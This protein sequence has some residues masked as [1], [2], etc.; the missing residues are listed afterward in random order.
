[1]TGVSAA[2]EVQGR[3]SYSSRMKGL[4]PELYQHSLISEHSRQMVPTTTGLDC[5]EGLSKQSTG[6]LLFLEP[7]PEQKVYTW[8]GE[9]GQAEPAGKE[10]PGDLRAVNR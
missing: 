1:M 10:A 7:P 2:A 8:P 6:A 4:L 5:P 3:H 9:R